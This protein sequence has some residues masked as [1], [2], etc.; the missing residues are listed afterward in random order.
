MR[1]VR[2][3]V[4]VHPDTPALSLL[5]SWVFR[6]IP[7]PGAQP[8]AGLQRR[9]A[10]LAVGASERVRGVGDK[11]A[12]CRRGGRVNDVTL[13]RGDCMDILPTLGRVDA[14]ITDPPYQMRGG[15]GVVPIRGFGVAK[16]FSDSYSIGEPWGYSLDWIDGLKRLCPKHIIV[17]CNSYMLGELCVKLQGFMEMGAVFVWQKPNAAPNCRN[18]PKW[19]CEFIV[20]VKRS[21]ATN[22][23]AKDFRS[24][25]IVEPFPQAGCFAQERILADVGKSAAH[26][27]QKPLRVLRL[28]VER[29]T[30]P[31]WLVLD[32]FAGSGTTGV[33]CVRT[34]RRF[35]GIELDPGYFA[36][37]QKRIAEAR[38]Q[39]RLFDEQRPRHETMPM[40]GEP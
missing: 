29:L 19:D 11:P 1:L 35:I 40:F 5:P 2:R 7:C 17:F 6:R 18:T 26:P 15:G 39:P 12:Q 25:V 13:I 9:L 27:T 20:W 10:V 14:V 21:D 30:D 36:I 33:A 37:A 22:V 38:L 8:W 4:A 32:P 24:Q 28:L 23:R 34:G 16:P 3:A 31:D